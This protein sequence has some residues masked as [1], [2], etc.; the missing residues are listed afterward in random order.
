MQNQSSTKTD[1][2]VCLR[3]YHPAKDINIV[4]V[5]DKVYII[6]IS[7][8]KEHLFMYRFRFVV[9]EASVFV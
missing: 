4:I 2:Q 3:I 5:S 6:Y 9:L 7:H 8:Y 1:I